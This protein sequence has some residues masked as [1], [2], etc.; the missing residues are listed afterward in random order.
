ME[1]LINHKPGEC[2]DLYSKSV[3]CATT[4]ELLE[5]TA[6]DVMLKNI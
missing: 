3:V 1:S 6:P 4:R 5:E 2:F